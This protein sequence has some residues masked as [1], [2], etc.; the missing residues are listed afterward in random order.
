MGLGRT[1]TLEPPNSK[2][3][4][5]HS[6]FWARATLDKVSDVVSGSGFVEVTVRFVPDEIDNS[7]AIRSLD[8]QISLGAVC[9]ERAL[10][11]RAGRLLSVHRASLTAHPA[12]S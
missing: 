2:G 5:A 9:T 3:G 8:G 11:G 12:D 7:G 10:P 1:L 6:E 4:E